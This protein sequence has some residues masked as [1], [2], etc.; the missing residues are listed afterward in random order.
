MF[1]KKQCTGKKIKILFT[2]KIILTHRP[3]TIYG[4]LNKIFGIFLKRIPASICDC[5]FIIQ[6]F[7]YAYFI[8]QIHHAKSFKMR[9]VT[10]LYINFSQR[11]S[12]KCFKSLKNKFWEIRKIV[13]MSS[14][15]FLSLCRCIIPWNYATYSFV[16]IHRIGGSAQYYFF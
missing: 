10:Y 4:Y 13:R 11:Y 16:K 15:Q 5:A 12:L 9:H 3:L 14:N 8:L 6:N 1:L 7:G 2:S